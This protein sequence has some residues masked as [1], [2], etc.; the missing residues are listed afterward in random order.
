MN[1]IGGVNMGEFRKIIFMLFLGLAVVGT[2]AC[3]DSNDGPAEEVGEKMDDV[4]EDVGDKMEDVGDK[5]EDAVDS[6]DN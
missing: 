5:A 2:Y 1:L 6:S 4:S 3:P